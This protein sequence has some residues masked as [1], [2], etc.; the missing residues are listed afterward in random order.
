MRNILKTPS[1]FLLLVVVTVILLISGISIAA[2]HRAPKTNPVDC[3]GDCRDNRDKTL[4][5]CDG[6]PDGAR[7]NC[8]ERANKQYDRCIERCNSG[9]SPG[10]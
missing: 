8:R 10:N 5:R 2:S 3:A 9:I 4:A 6:L 7:A 1:R